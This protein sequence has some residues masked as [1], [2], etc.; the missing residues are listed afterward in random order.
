MMDK[1]TR[2]DIATKTKGVRMRTTTIG[3]K[4]NINTETVEN[5]MPKTVGIIE[6]FNLFLKL[7]I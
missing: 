7:L 1:E 2:V 3:G 5:T 6:N 4:P